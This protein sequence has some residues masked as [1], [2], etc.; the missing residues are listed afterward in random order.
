MEP[1][2]WGVEESGVRIFGSDP[3]VGERGGESECESK[4]A[5]CE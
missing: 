2:D 1:L 4:M 5:S 3:D